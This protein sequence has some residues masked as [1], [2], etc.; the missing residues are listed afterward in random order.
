M[1]YFMIFIGFRGCMYKGLGTHPYFLYSFWSPPF[2]Q[3]LY[4][5][6]FR[7]T[8]QSYIRKYL[9]WGIPVVMKNIFHLFTGH[10]FLLN[11]NENYWLAAH[12]IY[13]YVKPWC[14]IYYKNFFCDKSKN[15]NVKCATGFLI[16][17]DC[18]QVVALFRRMLA[19]VPPQSLAL[20]LGVEVLPA[21]DYA[22]LHTASQDQDTAFDPQK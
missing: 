22:S 3:S 2:N 12:Q 15:K 16:V 19:D 13:F 8:Y 5:W 11:S 7:N 1:Q 18:P 4:D 17:V 20:I 14:V 10:I 6:I 21:H 9:L